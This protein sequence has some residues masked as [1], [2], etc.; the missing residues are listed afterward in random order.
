[1]QIKLPHPAKIGTVIINFADPDGAAVEFKCLVS[2]DG[3]EQ[4][5]LHVNNN[6]EHQVYRAQIAPVLTDTFRLE[7]ETSANPKYPNAAQ[8]SEIQLYADA[9]ASSPTK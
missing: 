8:V 2:I 6:Q 9:P 7:I 5:I 3:K 1:M 4:E